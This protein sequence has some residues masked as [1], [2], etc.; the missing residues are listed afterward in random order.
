[1]PWLPDNPS[2]VAGQASWQQ[3]TIKAG[4]LVMPLACVSM[5]M[6]TI[7]TSTRCSVYRPGQWRFSVMK[8]PTVNKP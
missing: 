6:A 4:P 3:A 7:S 1:L 8:Q 5:L 2:L